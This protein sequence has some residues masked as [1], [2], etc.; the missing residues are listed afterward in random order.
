MKLFVL[1][2]LQ[3]SIPSQRAPQGHGELAHVLAKR[4]HDCS[5]VLAG[6][7]DQHGKTRMALHQRSHARSRCPPSGQEWRGLRLPPAVPEWKWHRLDK[8][9]SDTSDCWRNSVDR[10]GCARRNGGQEGLAGSCWALRANTLVVTRRTP[11]FRRV[12]SSW[13]AEAS[14]H[15]RLW[16]LFNVEQAT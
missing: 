13:V 9:S 14:T 12:F 15:R 8:E 10:R 6:H 16:N 1:G 2:H 3:T 11:R 7:L 4:G 5:G